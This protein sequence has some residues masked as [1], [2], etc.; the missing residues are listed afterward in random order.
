MAMVAMPDAPS[1]NPDLVERRLSALLSKVGRSANIVKPSTGQGGFVVEIGGVHLAVLPMP[2]PIPAGTLEGALRFEYFW[3]D[4]PQVLANAKSHIIVSV[5]EPASDPRKTFNQARALTLL[6]DAVLEAANGTGVYW[7]PADCLI[8]PERL[9]AE[10]PSA[11]ENSIAPGLWFG[12]RLFPGGKID[13]KFAAVCQST[14]LVPFLGREVEC[15][16]YALETRELAQIVLAVA[17]SMATEGNVF[18]EGHILT[19]ED[20][21]RIGRLHLDWSTMGGQQ[22][23]VF[24]LRLASQEAELFQ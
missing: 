9:R 8:S 2:F 13:G 23:P 20:G 21:T 4:A 5:T 12:F 19:S 14:G 18:D 22:T 11:V 15:G 6:T 24:H 16:P 17:R 7:T 1:V 10:A 3:R